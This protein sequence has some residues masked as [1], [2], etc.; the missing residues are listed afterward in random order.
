MI[1]NVEEL[2]KE[3]EE[4]WKKIIA[5]DALY[6]DAFKPSQPV[7]NQGV[8]GIL[9]V[10]TQTKDQSE[11]QDNTPLDV[12]TDDAPPFLDSSVAPKIQ[13]VDTKPSGDTVAIDKRDKG[14]KKDVE[15]IE[16]KVVEVH[17][18]KVQLV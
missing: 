6:K 3:T 8:L 5:N 9:K 11:D 13:Q 2:R 17:K 14:E 7:D 1:G 16:A 12:E 18:E 10:E 15:T 4:I